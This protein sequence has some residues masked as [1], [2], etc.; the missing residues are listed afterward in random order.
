MKMKYIMILALALFAFGLPQADA[1]PKKKGK[2]RAKT[3]QK[4]KIKADDDVDTS[5]LN[6]DDADTDLDPDATDEPIADEEA[7]PER[8]LTAAERREENEMLKADTK[9]Y[10]DNQRKTF[11]IL[12]RVRDS[13]TALKAVPALEKIYGPGA[14]T[15]AS[16]G[17]VTALGTVKIFEEDEES[18]GV[19]PAFR[20]I[21]AALNSNVNR[22]LKR[23]SK[24]EIDCPEFDAVI[25]N[26]ID[27]QRENSG[28]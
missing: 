25:K 2:K 18:L 23:I 19:H 20:A 8:R 24:L 6:D 13:K 7:E 4:A 1:A 17:T 10:M 28:Q 22:E 5:L 26:M 21:V 3:Q 12:R 16:A 27:K 14:P 11:R 9:F 15:S